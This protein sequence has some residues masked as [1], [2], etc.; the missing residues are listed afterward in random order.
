MHVAFTSKLRTSLSFRSSSKRS[1]CCFPHSFSEPLPQPTNHLQPRRVLF[2]PLFSLASIS[3]FVLS[4]CS[5][6]AA[7]S[8]RF[9]SVTLLSDSHNSNTAFATITGSRVDSDSD[10]L[11]F[12]KTSAPKYPSITLQSSATCDPDTQ[13]QC[14]K[15]RYMYTNQASLQHSRL[16]DRQHLQQLSSRVACTSK[17]VT[18]TQ[19]RFQDRLSAQSF[20][21]LAS[22]IC[23]RLGTYLSLPTYRLRP[24]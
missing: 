16:Y 13:T 15:L 24:T 11:S 9:F 8:A 18:S 23:F 2:T 14:F 10:T 22:D 3:A 12:R 7:A 6:S 21:T 19:L 1:D 5:T 4:D 20:S 17:L